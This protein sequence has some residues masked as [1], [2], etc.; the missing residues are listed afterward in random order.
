MNV[1][2]LLPFCSLIHGHYLVIFVVAHMVVE[3]L[4]L[5]QK[6]RAGLLATA[7]INSSRQLRTS[8]GFLSNRLRNSSTAAS[9]EG[10]FKSR[11]QEI[12][13]ACPDP[14][15]RLESDQRSMSCA[16]FRSQYSHLADNE[17]VEDSVVV[18]HG[19]S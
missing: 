15:P 18:V 16:E 2:K 11:L 4:W 8:Q 5:I 19:R 14:Y 6:D 9:P 10:A 13:N 1:L 17:T 7:S 3:T 12:Q